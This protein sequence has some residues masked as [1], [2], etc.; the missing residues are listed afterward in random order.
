MSTRER[1][2]VPV[3]RPRDPDPPAAGG[4]TEAPAKKA[5]RKPVLLKYEQ[6]HGI[7]LGSN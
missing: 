7:G 1:K 4:T 2:E 3:G 5:Y 6:L